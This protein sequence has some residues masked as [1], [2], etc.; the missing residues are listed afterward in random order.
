MSFDD[1]LSHTKSNINNIDDDDNTRIFRI[2][3]M[4]IAMNEFDDHVL[5]LLKQRRE[6]PEFFINRLIIDP[7]ND[8]LPVGL[9]PQLVENCTCIAEV[10]V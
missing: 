8:Q 3:E 6:R 9:I 1:A 5:A 10:G 2:F 4:W 7:R